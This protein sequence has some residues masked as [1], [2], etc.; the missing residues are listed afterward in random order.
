[1]E[2]TFPGAR[3]SPAALAKS[4]MS[5]VEGKTEAEL[6]RKELAENVSD[7]LCINYKGRNVIHDGILLKFNQMLEMN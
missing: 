1:M 2:S 7:G 5:Y 3:A 6:D 4:T